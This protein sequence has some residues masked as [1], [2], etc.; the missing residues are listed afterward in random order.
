[1]RLRH[2]LPFAAALALAGCNGQPT[3]KTDGAARTAIASPA[4]AACPQAAAPVCPPA[5]AASAHHGAGQ[6]VS[7]VAAVRHRPVRAA[8]AGHR[9]TEASGRRY[10]W[11]HYDDLSGGPPEPGQ[12]RVYARVPPGGYVRE[13]DD[14]NFGYRYGPG[15]PPAPRFDERRGEDRRS[16][17]DG[18]RDDRPDVRGP[19]GRGPD[20]RRWD[21]R[22]DDGPADR[23]PPESG[24]YYRQ[25][26]EGRAPDRYSAG[27]GSSAGG[28]SVERHSSSESGGSHVQGGYSRDGATYDYDRQRDEGRAV[29]GYRERRSDATGRSYRAEER[30][31]ESTSS[32]STERRTWGDGA[33]GCCDSSVG[34]A[35]FDR[36][37]YLTWPG[38]VPARP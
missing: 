14:R 5:K 11:R 3:N 6:A 4:P 9:V 27:Q 13:F 17:D 8:P 22:R 36:N 25:G 12:G 16:Y 37:G 29:S 2:V 34:A 33:S 26:A 7:H 32:S 1:M 10:T 35:G 15:Y 24:Y 38:K 31:S 18:R 30:S 21:G 20:D 19:D 28:P 23:A